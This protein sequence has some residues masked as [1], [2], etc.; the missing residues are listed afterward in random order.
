MGFVAAARTVW[1]ICRDPNDPRGMLLLTVKN[2]L[3]PL[4]TGLAY[5]IEPN[6]QLAAPH[7]AWQSQ[8]VEISLAD[9]FK[10][11]PRSAAPKPLNAK[12]PASG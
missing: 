6:S 3:G 2:N 8:P 7:L 1:T 11:R 10:P 9:A 5:T 12:K 4:G